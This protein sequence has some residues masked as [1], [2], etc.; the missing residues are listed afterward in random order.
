MESGMTGKT[1]Q[2]ILIVDDNPSIHDDFRKILSPPE[3]TDELDVL[4]SSLFG[5]APVQAT[6]DHYLLDSA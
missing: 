5:T 6:R 3:T 4:E 2:R 1:P